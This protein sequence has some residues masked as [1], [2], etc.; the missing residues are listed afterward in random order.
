MLSHEALHFFA[1]GVFV[2][3]HQQTFFFLWFGLAL[4]IDVVAL[5]IKWGKNMFR[6]VILLVCYKKNLETE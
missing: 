4:Y 3:L 5:I 2:L 1:L 6:D